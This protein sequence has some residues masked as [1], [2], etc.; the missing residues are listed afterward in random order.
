MQPDVTGPAWLRSTFDAMKTFTTLLLLTG[1]WTWAGEMPADIPLPTGFR[2]MTQKERAV[3]DDLKTRLEAAIASREVAAVAALYQ[4]NEVSAVEWTSELARWRPVLEKGAKPSPP[5]LKI[6]SQLPPESKKHW[7]AEAHRRTR[8][9]VTAF[10]MVGFQN[11]SQMT[12]PLVLVGDKLLIVPSEKL[13]ARGI[14]P[15]A[16]PNAV[17]PH[18]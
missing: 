1:L 5:F 13:A 14:E 12:M 3:Y 17:P 6:L 8:Q 15:A 16:P 10:A 18:R 7:E 11:A 2:Q 4:T 9:Q